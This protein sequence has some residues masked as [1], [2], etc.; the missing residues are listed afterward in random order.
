[1]GSPARTREDNRILLTSKEVGLA[2]T[3]A[4]ARWGVLHA[5]RSVLKQIGT[6]AVRVLGTVHLL[7]GN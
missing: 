5:V 3:G 6:A 2:F 1:M 4:L 7:L